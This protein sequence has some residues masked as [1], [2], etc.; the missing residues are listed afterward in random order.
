[1]PSLAAICAQ[2]GWLETM[3]G[4]STR[5]S[6]MRQRYSRSTRQWSYLETITTT[7]GRWSARR[8]MTVAAGSHLDQLRPDERTIPSLAARFGV[9]RFSLGVGLSARRSH[10]GVCARSQRVG[11]VVPRRPAAQVRG[12]QRP[13]TVRV[14]TDPTLQTSAKARQEFQQRVSVKRRIPCR[15]RGF[16]WSGRPDSNRR[17]SPWQGRNR[18]PSDPARCRRLRFHPPNRPIDTASIG[19]S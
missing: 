19:L 8:T 1:M 13:C 9:E 12:R 15:G 16:P 5:R 14:A 10:P 11:R 4:M 2:S 17:P 3:S 18:R 6:P 7:C